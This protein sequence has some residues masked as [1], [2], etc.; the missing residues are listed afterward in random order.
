MG[1][2]KIRNILPINVPKLYGGRIY[3]FDKKL[4]KSSDIFHLELGLYP[5][6]TD[7]VEAVKILILERQ[8]HSENCMRGK[9]SRRTQKV[10]IYLANE[11]SGLV[12]FWYGSGTY[13]WK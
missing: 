13:F 3:I 9:V 2:C 1:G 5:F 8:N 10:E 7:I 11:G 12:F 4:S 6:I